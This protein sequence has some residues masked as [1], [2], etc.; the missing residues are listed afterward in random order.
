MTTAVWAAKCRVA[1]GM[2][3]P[4]T[5]TSAMSPSG[6][7]STA[8]KPAKS[9]A[10]RTV[11]AARLSTLDASG[12]RSGLTRKTAVA[13]SQYQCACCPYQRL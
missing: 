7:G 12:P 9:K 4:L 1:T 10:P 5:A 3:A 8:A 2:R 11:P 6:R 13:G